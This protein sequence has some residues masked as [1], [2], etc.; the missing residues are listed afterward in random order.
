MLSHSIVSDFLQPL[1]LQPAR[2]LCPWDFPGINTAVGCHFLLQVDLGIELESP[3]QAEFFTSEP[4]VNPKI[5]WLL[6][7]TLSL[8]KLL[9]PLLHLALILPLSCQST[10]P[11]FCK[12]PSKPVWRLCSPT[13]GIRSP[14]ISVFPGQPSKILLSQF[15]KNPPILDNSSYYFSSHRLPST[16]PLLCSLAINSCFSLVYFQFTILKSLLHYYSSF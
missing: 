7:K 12:N 8:T 11:N 14:L 10:Q 15:S 4:L 13:L 16:P 2:L 5:L 1:E 9:C 6:I 3:A